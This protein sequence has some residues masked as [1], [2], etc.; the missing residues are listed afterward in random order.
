[1][2]SRIQIVSLAMLVSL[3][4]CATPRPQP[5]VDVRLIPNDCANRVLIINYLQ[6]LA[7]RSKQ[8]FESERDYEIH[9]S[10]VRQRI[11]S[12]RYHCQ[13]V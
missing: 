11:W 7:D 5:P 2:I 3:S 10:Q 12:M 9:R 4:G 8:T 13:P 6:Q 1:M